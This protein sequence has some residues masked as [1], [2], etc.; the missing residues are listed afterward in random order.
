MRKLVS[1]PVTDELQ[2][3]AGSFNPII[4]SNNIMSHLSDSLHKATEKRADLLAKMRQ[5]MELE[6]LALLENEVQ[7]VLR[8]T[9]TKTSDSELVDTAI[10]EVAEVVSNNTK[11]ILAY[12]VVKAEVHRSV[13]TVPKHA[14]HVL[15]TNSIYNALVCK[16]RIILKNKCVL[17]L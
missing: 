12:P 1:K 4:L 9:F 17:A 6:R 5:R 15:I 10:K 2:C 13:S 14:E 11:K 16:I 8:H 7:N 3:F